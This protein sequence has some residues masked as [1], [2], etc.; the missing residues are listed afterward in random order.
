MIHS[1]KLSRRIARFRLPAVVLAL[2]AA[3][4]CD[5]GNSFNSDSSTQPGLGETGTDPHVGMPV[6]HSTPAEWKDTDL[7]PYR[8]LLAG[9]LYVG[10]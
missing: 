4:G 6:L 1:F 9:G 5:N 10:G 2:A 3:I 7:A 8:T